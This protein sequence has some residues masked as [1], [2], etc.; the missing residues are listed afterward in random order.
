MEW[1]A[2]VG[3]LN[4]FIDRIKLDDTEVRIRGPVAALAGGASGTLPKPSD[5][6]PN[7]V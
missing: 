5:A 4:L 2:G 6:V 1:A 3:Y 7:Y